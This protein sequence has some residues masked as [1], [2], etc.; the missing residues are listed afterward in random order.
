MT[1]KINDVIEETFMDAFDAAVTN[2]DEEGMKSEICNLVEKFDIDFMSGGR[3]QKLIRRLVEKT[4]N[5][6]YHREIIGKNLE[7]SLFE[8]E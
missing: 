8:Y 7:S 4:T 1:E 5:S 6:N 3:V 2:F